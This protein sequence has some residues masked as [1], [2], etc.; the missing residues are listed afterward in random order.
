MM[1]VSRYLAAVFRPAQRGGKHATA[2]VLAFVFS[3]PPAVSA[4]EDE[5]IVGL[6]PRRNASEMVEMFGP[7]AQY[8]SRQLNRPV[9]LETTPDF[10]SFWKAVAAQRYH[11]VHYNQYHYVRSRKEFGYR[12]V[13]K[14]EESHRS[15]LASVILVRKD[16]GIRTLHDLRNKRIVFGGNEQAMSSYIVPAYLLRQAGLGEQDYERAFALN[17]PNAVL[18]VFFRQADAAGSGDI[19]FNMP[20]IHEKVDVNQMEYLKKSEPIAHL[21]WAVRSDISAADKTRIQYALIKI[22]KDPD[23]HKILKAAMLTNLVVASDD[24]YD[25]VREIIR[26]VTG[27]QY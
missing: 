27:E 26:V 19:V 3:L 23:G 24:E 10:D 2:A 9:K 7:L 11:L 6:L 22:R 5:L 8:L 20:F 16:S 1:L 18:A 21:P 13:A 25:R 15:T 17:P 12:V 4:Q 14:N